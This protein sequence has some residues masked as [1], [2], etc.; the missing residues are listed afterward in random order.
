M[1]TRGSPGLCVEIA[2][3]KMQHGGT[4]KL[5]PTGSSDTWSNRSFF[6]KSYVLP[7]L[8]FRQSAGY[9]VLS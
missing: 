6:E 3:K 2:K 5:F 1:Q 8:R 4:E 9:E 7:Q